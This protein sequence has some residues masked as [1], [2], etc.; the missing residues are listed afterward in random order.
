MKM[1]IPEQKKTN[2][3]VN[4]CPIGGAPIQVHA[5]IIASKYKFMNSFNIFTHH[6]VIRSDLNAIFAIVSQFNLTVLL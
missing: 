2:S 3:S 6:N 1:K 5:C 4:I